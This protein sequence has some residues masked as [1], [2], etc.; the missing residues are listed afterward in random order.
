MAVLSSQEQVSTN[1]NMAVRRYLAFLTENSVD[2]VS[3]VFR[4]SSPPG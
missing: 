2:F 4:L 3:M 1:D